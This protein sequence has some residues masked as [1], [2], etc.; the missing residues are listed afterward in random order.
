MDAPGFAPI[1][2][3]PT[4]ITKSVISID[5]SISS[6]FVT[7]R[8]VRMAD[9]KSKSSHMDFQSFCVKYC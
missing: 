6:Q 7:H 5:G 4:Q 9:K 8:V 1:K 3:E 2:I